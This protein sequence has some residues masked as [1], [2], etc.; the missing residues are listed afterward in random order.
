MTYRQLEEAINK[1]SPSQK[2]GPVVIFFTEDDLY[3]EAFE[4]TQDNTP[5]IMCTE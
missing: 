5:M 4:I 3:L 1:M 2:D